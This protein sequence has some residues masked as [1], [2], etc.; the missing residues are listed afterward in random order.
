[1]NVLERLA[2]L[3]NNNTEIQLFHWLNDEWSFSIKRSK[4]SVKLEINET[5][6][7]IEELMTK[8]MDKFESAIGKGLPELNP[9]LEY[10]PSYQP[11]GPGDTYLGPE[12]E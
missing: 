8:V 3:T 11:T 5:G 1:M 2:T 6:T 9:R 10:Q 7:N 4:H 12:S